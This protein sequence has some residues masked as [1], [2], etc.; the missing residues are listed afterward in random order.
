MIT[1]CNRCGVNVVH[2]EGRNYHACGRLAKPRPSGGPGTE[3]EKL[4][5]KFFADGGCECKSYAR[6]MDRWG[7][8]GCEERFDEIVSH[9]VKQAAKVRIV[10]LF[11]PVNRMVAQRW[12]TRAIDNSRPANPVIDSGDWFVAITTSPR[13]DCTLLRCIDS[14][15]RAGWEPTVFADPGSTECNA[16]TIR[17]ADRLGVWHNWLASARYALEHSTASTILTVQDDSIFHPDSRAFAESILWPADDAA[18]VSLYTPRHYTYLKNGRVNPAGVNRIRT[19]SLWGACALAWRREVLA[20][21][22]DSRA[23]KAWRGAGPRKGDMAA[24]FA[25]K[26]ADPSK[27]ANSDTAIGKAVNQLGLSMWFIDPSPVHHVARY[28][29]LGHGG[30]GGNRNCGR[31]SDH[32]RPLAEQVFPPETAP[33]KLF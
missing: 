12:V 20:Q 22:V 29:T 13:K 32:S 9:L 27:I 23:A 1:K 19:R 5:P 6:K 16:D 28:S 33:G 15:R 21:V 26:D 7:V 11:G 30:N 14:V 10:N 17:N 18:F 31:C 2:E 24:W 3:L 25:A 4:I 8:D